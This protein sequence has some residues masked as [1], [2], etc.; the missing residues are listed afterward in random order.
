MK[1]KKS[2][3]VLAAI[4]AL[5]AAFPL[6][7]KYPI[8]FGYDL[9]ASVATTEQ[10]KA[11]DNKVNYRDNRRDYEAASKLC[12]TLRAAGQEFTCP[13]I[14]DAAGIAYFLRNHKSQTTTAVTASSGSKLTTSKLTTNQRDLLRWYRKINTCPTTLK[15][16][17]PAF[18]E[19]CKSFL[20]PHPVLYQGLTNGDENA[21][22]DVTLDD[23]TKANKGV[24]RTQK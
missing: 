24:R 2:E 9:T 16:D 22:P 20:N 7:V 8:A 6:A 18:Y 13:D 19:L 5:L 17:M 10:Q 12:I 11:L 21:K 4:F 14:N 1:F 15:A 23:Y 3:Y